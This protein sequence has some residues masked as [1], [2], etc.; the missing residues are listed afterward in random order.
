MNGLDQ[1]IDLVSLAWEKEV[2]KEVEEDISAQ[3]LPAI[4]RLRGA[5][6]RFLTCWKGEEGLGGEG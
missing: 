2:A 5:A 1:F 4:E 3:S 6:R